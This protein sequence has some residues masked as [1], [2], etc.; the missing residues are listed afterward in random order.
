MVSE[1]FLNTECI[2]NSHPNSTLVVLNLIKVAM[3]WLEVGNLR[4]SIQGCL[5][6]IY[7]L[8]CCEVGFQKSSYNLILFRNK[9]VKYI[10]NH[11]SVKRLCSKCHLRIALTST[12]SK[13]RTSFITKNEMAYILL[14]YLNIFDWIL[15]A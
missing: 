5:L 8:N 13:I 2:A 10:L 1:V 14:M 3:L 15:S 12:V 4:L 9:C 11:L 7:R 6:Y